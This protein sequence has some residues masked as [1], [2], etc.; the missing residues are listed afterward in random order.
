MAGREHRWP[1]P[2]FTVEWA[3]KL[4]TGCECSCIV[5]LRSSTKPRRCN[6]VNTTRFLVS[7]GRLSSQDSNLHLLSSVEVRRA[8]RSALSPRCAVCAAHCDRRNRS[9]ARH[10]SESAGPWGSCCS[11]FCG[12]QSLNKADLASGLLSDEAYGP[13]R[14]SASAHVCGRH[15]PSASCE[16][17]ASAPDDV[18][19]GENTQRRP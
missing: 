18:R 12:R 1:C 13:L 19:R 6:A 5:P 8:S 17:N 14:I 7:P 11:S 15:L 10:S 3:T 4:L 2:A 16:S 9:A